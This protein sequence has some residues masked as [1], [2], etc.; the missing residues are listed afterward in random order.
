VRPVS[1]AQS[2]GINF[3]PRTPVAQQLR[4]RMAKENVKSSVQQILERQPTERE[5]IS[6]SYISDKV[7]V[8][9]IYRELKKLNS[10]RVS[11]LMKKWTD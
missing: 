10:Q 11:D 3:L 1:K 7:L 4:E 8:T 5:K 9:R 6:A 2:I